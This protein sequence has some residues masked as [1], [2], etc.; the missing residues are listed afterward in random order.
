MNF[1]LFDGKS[2]YVSESNSPGW[3]VSLY[4]L[5]LRPGDRPPEISFDTAWVNRSGAYFFL[6]SNHETRKRGLYLS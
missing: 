4:Y 1:Q 2:L 6:P 3:A 5:M